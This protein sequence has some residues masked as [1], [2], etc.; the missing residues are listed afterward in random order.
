MSIFRR[1]SISLMGGA[2][3]GDDEPRPP[4]RHRHSLH[5]PQKNYDVSPTGGNRP[6]SITADPR[7]SFAP[8]IPPRD[9]SRT[10]SGPTP[11]PP[12]P[13]PP[14]RPPHNHH[15]H[16]HRHRSDTG[17]RPRKHRTSTSTRARPLSEGDPAPRRR[18]RRSEIPADLEP[19]SPLEIPTPL[20]APIPI[21]APRAAAAFDDDS[22][23]IAASPTSGSS[24]G[25]IISGHHKRRGSGASFPSPSPACASPACTDAPRSIQHPAD[26][27]NPAHAVP[28]RAGPPCKHASGLLRLPRRRPAAVPRDPARVTQR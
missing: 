25:I 17:E 5:R 15:H 13:S 3:S 18:R 2:S 27:R 14:P 10:I 11:P 26:H 8:D 28:A 16:H 24:M 12:Q 21:R 20:S 19:V 7:V 6:I 1:L 22:P 9:P 4:H 23:R